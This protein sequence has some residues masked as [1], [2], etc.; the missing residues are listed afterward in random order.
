MSI[1]VIRMCE[2][3]NVVQSGLYLRVRWRLIM[4]PKDVLSGAQSAVQAAK[5]A[6]GNLERSVPAVTLDF[7]LDFMVFPSLFLI[8]FGGCHCFLVNSGVGF[9]WF[10]DSQSVRGKGSLSS[11]RFSEASGR[12]D[13]PGFTS[14]NRKGGGVQFHL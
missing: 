13:F 10:T 9:K 12:L 11:W 4:I 3:V 1:S 7:Y 2:V 5:G 14:S 6:F 8:F